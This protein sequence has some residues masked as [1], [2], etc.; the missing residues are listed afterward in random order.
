MG[1]RACSASTKAAMPPCFCAS[2]IT[3]SA[4][5]VLP[6]DSGPK[7]STTRPRGKPPT[8]RAASKEMEPVEI[9]EMGTKKTGYLVRVPIT[10]DYGDC[11]RLQRSPTLTPHSQPRRLLTGVG[12]PFAEKPALD[13]GHD[14]NLSFA[15]GHAAKGE[16]K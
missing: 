6:L 13:E 12:M 3:W 8:P 14:T 4:I 2:A 5:V 15:G 11:V 9:T 10:R 7:T 1:S 16:P